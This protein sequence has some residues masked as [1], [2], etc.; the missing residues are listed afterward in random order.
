MLAVGVWGTSV[1]C[2]CW[3]EEECVIMWLLV[4]VLIIVNGCVLVCESGCVWSTGG[5][6]CVWG[7]VVE[8]GFG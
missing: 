4:C 2:V 6:G 7:W 5:F 3:G 8:Y 1:W